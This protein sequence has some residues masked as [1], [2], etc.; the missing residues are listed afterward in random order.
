MFVRQPGN[1]ALLEMDL[2][3]LDLCKA[4]DGHI[5]ELITLL[6][7]AERKP[8]TKLH[9]PSSSCPFQRVSCAHD[10]IGPDSVRH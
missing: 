1:F 6:L 5:K 3:D 8:V 10:A 4:S 7:M 9:I 2:D